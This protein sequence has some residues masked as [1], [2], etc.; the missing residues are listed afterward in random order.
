MENTMTLTGILS[1]PMPFWMTAENVCFRA[2][3]P[4][5]LIE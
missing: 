1:E 2:I 5:H 4:K 3:A